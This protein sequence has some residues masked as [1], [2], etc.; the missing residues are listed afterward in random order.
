MTRLR[1][2]SRGRE[3]GAV[4]P[5]GPA[6]VGHRVGSSQGV[7]RYLAE[8]PGYLC[9][10]FLASSVGAP[11]CPT[12]MITLDLHEVDGVASAHNV[13]SR[14]DK[15]TVSTYSSR[16]EV[17]GLHDSFRERRISMSPLHESVVWDATSFAAAPGPSTDNA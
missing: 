11:P 5:C 16:T 4:L 8:H 1:R 10:E 7:S 6:G 12:A 13:C 9:A 3:P 14:V 17:H 2:R 15:V